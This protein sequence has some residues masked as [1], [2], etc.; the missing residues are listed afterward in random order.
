MEASKEDGGGAG[1]VLLGACW[2]AFGQ[3]PVDCSFATDV[4]APGESGGAA[5]LRSPLSG[6]RLRVVS[7]PRV[8]GIRAL[9]RA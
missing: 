3:T 6:A 4:T 7:T 5:D 1:R 2:Y 8:H 9:N